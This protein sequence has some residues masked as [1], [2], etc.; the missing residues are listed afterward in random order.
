MVNFALLA[1]AAAAG[2]A[3][4]PDS[5][6]TSAQAISAE[7]QARASVRIVSGA[8]ILADQPPSEATVREVVLDEAGDGQ[9]A[10]RLVEFP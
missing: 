3:P 1:L 9:R 10:V 5:P 7:T 8:R 2:P 4:A 6:G